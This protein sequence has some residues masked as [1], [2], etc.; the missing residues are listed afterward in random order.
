M[1]S[2]LVGLVKTL[3]W[4]DFQ[5]TPDPNKPNLQA[6]TKADF[7][8]P[9]ISPTVIPG[10]RNFRFEDNVVVTINMDTQRSWKRQPPDA[11]LVH[12]Q[13][14][15]DIVALLARDLFIEV[16]QLK[17]RTYPNHG[18]AIADLRPIINKFNGKAQAISTIYD[19][20][21]QTNHGND[22]VQQVRWN[23]MFR[24][25]FS[26][27]RSPQVTAPDGAVYK[28]PILDVLSQNGVNP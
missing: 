8:L 4:S 7:V 19:A 3:A 27:P 6:F 11:L 24:R 14:H 23:G 16:M 2:R 5:G 20:P 13:G 9:V 22:P 25:A 21:A 1:P 28:I 10:T 15:Y 12:E 18:A 17:T 26:E